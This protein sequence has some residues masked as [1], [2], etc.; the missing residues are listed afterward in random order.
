M[1]HRLV[2]V[3]RQPAAVRVAV[4]DRF[5]VSLPASGSVTA[6]APS[7]SP[8]ASG[9]SH[10]ARCV[11]VPQRLTVQATIVWTVRRLRIEEQPRPISSWT[12]PSSVNGRPAPP[13]AAGRKGAHRPAADIVRRNSS[14]MRPSR[15][16]R[17]AAGRTC[18]RVKRRAASAAP[19]TPD[20]ATAG[21]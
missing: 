17:S 4:A 18:S 7:S 10:R 12:R 15:S 11:S 5:A 20:A 21:L 8:D 16:K 13:K 14:G 9:G 6:T 1:I 3:R 19:P 2:A